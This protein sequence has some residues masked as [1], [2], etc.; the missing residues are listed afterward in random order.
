M[1]S[2]PLFS[3]TSPGRSSFLT[4]LWVRA[5]FRTLRS[6]FVSHHNWRRRESSILCMNIAFSSFE[7]IRM[8]RLSRNQLIGT[9][10]RLSPVSTFFP[11]RPSSPSPVRPQE[12]P[13]QAT[14]VPLTCQH[15]YYLFCPPVG[16]IVR[17]KCLIVRIAPSQVRRG[18]GRGQTRLAPILRSPVVL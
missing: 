18:P 13:P 14:T 10:L 9:R 4:S 7:A 16:K 1:S 2:S 11:N 8:V 15:S 6:T 5:P 3:Y 12:L 17:G